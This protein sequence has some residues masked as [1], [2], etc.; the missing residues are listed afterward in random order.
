M[1]GHNES[2]EIYM[3]AGVQANNAGLHTEALD[4]RFAAYAAADGDIEAGRAARD[5]GHSFA[6]LSDDGEHFV[7]GNLSN[8]TITEQ[9]AAL[10]GAYAD[11]ALW[12]HGQARKSREPGAE[13]EYR[14]SAGYVGTMALRRAIAAEQDGRLDIKAINGARQY[15]AEAAAG[16]ED[17]QYTINFAGRYASAISLY[18]SGVRGRSLAR[19]AWRLAK[20]SESSEL[21]HS[22]PNL[23][24]IERKKAQWKAKSRAAGA[25][26]VG[27]PGMSIQAAPEGTPKRLRSMALKLADRLI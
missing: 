14:A 6:A 18:E 25:F 7:S 27:L 11:H 22:T 23:S 19:K 3:D 1:S 4:M 16:S 15:L 9:N 21:P 26:V 20:Q 8:G 2:F 12:L 10:A 17:D 5:I 13:R 24:A